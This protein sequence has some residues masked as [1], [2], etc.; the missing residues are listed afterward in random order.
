M[1][2]SNEL[3]PAESERDSSE[4]AA[5]ERDAFGQPIRKRR[6]APP[7]PVLIARI[8]LIASSLVGA[9][10]TVLQ[11][12]DRR[13]L[14]TQLRHVAPQLGQVDVD[15]AVNSGVLFGLLTSALGVLVTIMLT[16]RMIGGQQWA[17]VVLTVFTGLATFNVL[18]VLG[19]LGL[20]GSTGVTQLVGMPIGP[21]DIG[22]NLVAAGLDVAAVVFMFSAEANTFFRAVRE[23]LRTRRSPARAWSGAS[24]GR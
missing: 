10:A 16:N 14:I 23:Q 24:R 18:V 22:S 5:A 4:P 15:S 19:M 8:L 7:K 1:N 2:A 13:L 12:S 21:V 11:L 17:R 20:I 3:K 9:A 6:S